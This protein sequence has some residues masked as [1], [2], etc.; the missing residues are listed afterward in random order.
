MN[1][2]KIPV[3]VS[4][5]NNL[6]FAAATLIVSML[7][8]A[9]KDT[10]YDIH[11][12]CTGN[13]IKEDKEKLQ[14]LTLKYNNFSL[15]F[16]D[17]KDTFK[18]I[19]KTHEHVNYVSAYKFL[20]PSLFPQF[21]KILYLDADIIVRTDLTDLYN[22]D[23]GDNYIAGCIN[24]FNQTIK[25][26]DLMKETGIKSMDYYINA[27]VMLMNLKKIRQDKIDKQCIDMIGSFKGSVDQHIINKVCYD[28][29][30]FIPLKYNVTQSSLQ[31][32]ETKTSKNFYS[33][34]EAEQAYNNPAIFHW[35]G[36]LKPWKYYN[37]FLA[38]E[39]FRYFIKTPFK[40][41]TLLRTEAKNLNLISLIKELLKKFIISVIYR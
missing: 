10:F 25:R 27:G 28:K 32:L 16:T 9:N 41:M 14:E 7:E 6:F 36:P 1:T 40:D 20:I 24:L 38:H 4:S 29:I 35:T 15:S 22:T 18:D 30:F 19:P 33:L 2:N 26:K 17:M 37:L 11:F 12:L 23:I 34:Q 13:V 31:F 3:I 39:W 5:D 8:N 21:D